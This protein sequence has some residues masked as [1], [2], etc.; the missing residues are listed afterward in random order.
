[1]AHFILTLKTLHLKMKQE[2]STVWTTIFYVVLIICI[3]QYLFFALPRIANSP[4]AGFAMLLGSLLPNSIIVLIFWFIKSKSE[5][6]NSE[7]TSSKQSSNSNYVTQTL[8]NEIPN[9]NSSSKHTKAMPVNIQKG[10]SPFINKIKSNI[11]IGN[12]RLLLIISSVFS[13]ALAIFFSS[14]K[15]CYHNEACKCATKISFPTLIFILPIF[16]L[17]F[18]LITLLII[19][20]KEGYKIK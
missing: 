5:K 19:W 3:L 15:T 2:K 9:Y 4:N 13:L 7:D 1:M 17:V 18:W 11:S 6:G 20:V 12:Q 8:E 16:F 10:N 14:E